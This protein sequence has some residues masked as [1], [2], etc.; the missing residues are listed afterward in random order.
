[1]VI[2]YTPFLE[3]EEAD[4]PNLFFFLSLS[5]PSFQDPSLYLLPPLYLQI[6]VKWLSPQFE[7]CLH[8]EAKTAKLQS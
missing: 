5:F 3:S 8:S 4:S 2:K 7:V 6:K 1:M